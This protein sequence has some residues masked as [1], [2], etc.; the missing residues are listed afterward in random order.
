MKRVRQHVTFFTWL[1]SYIYIYV[2]MYIF[3]CNLSFLVNTKMCLCAYIQVSMHNHGTYEGQI[4]TSGVILREAV[5]L[6]W[7]RGSH[8]PEVTH[9]T[10][11]AGRQAPE[12]IL[13]LLPQCRGD[14][15]HLTWQSVLEVE[16]RSSCSW[17]L[18]WAFLPNT[19]SLHLSFTQGS[20]DQDFV[21]LY[22]WVISQYIIMPH[23]VYSLI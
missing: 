18:Y 19:F 11:T 8:S 10:M 4:S 9:L 12:T 20:C 3:I 2:Y 5:H 7:G 21:S 15:H 6:S 23:F 1:L 13:S 14:V 17:V 22:C 16:L